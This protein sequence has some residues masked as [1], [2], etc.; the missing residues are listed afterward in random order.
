MLYGKCN[1]RINIKCHETDQSNCAGN[2]NIRQNLIKN[3]K[4]KLSFIIKEQIQND[5]KYGKYPQILKNIRIKPVYKGGEKV[6]PNNYRPLCI[7]SYFTKI[8]IIS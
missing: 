4:D 1:N 5:L 3:H 8:M 2:D 6:N 7:S